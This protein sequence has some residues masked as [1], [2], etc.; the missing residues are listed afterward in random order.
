MEPAPKKWRRK[1]GADSRKV[2]E[3]ELREAIGRGDMAPGHRLVESDLME[4][5][6]MTRNGV[7]LALDA[8][9]ADGLVERIPNKSARVRLVTTEE[10]V[11]IMQCRQVLDGL[12]CRRA[13]ELAT[14]EEVARL[15]AHRDRMRAAVD[16]DEFGPYTD[17]IQEHHL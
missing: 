4:Q 13:A 17:L 12:L 10:A 3:N 1:H 2:I 7:R 11:A 16:A 15:V 6:G 5:F 9:V 8:L 14:D